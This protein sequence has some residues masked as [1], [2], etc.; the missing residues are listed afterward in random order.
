MAGCIRYCMVSSTGCT[1]LVV[2]LSNKDV[3]KPSL[4]ASMHTTVGGSWQWSPTRTADPLPL[5]C[6][7]G[8][9]FA[10]SVACAASSTITFANAMSESTGWSTL[11]HVQQTTSAFVKMCFSPSQ[12]L[13]CPEFIPIDLAFSTR[14]CF[15]KSSLV[16]SGRPT[17]TTF[18]PARAQPSTKLSTATLLSA[19]TNTGVRPSAVHNRTNSTAVWVLPVPGG[20]WINVIRRVA[21][22]LSASACDSLAKDHAGHNV[23]KLHRMPIVQRAASAPFAARSPSSSAARR[24]ALS[25]A[26]SLG[27][28]HIVRNASICRTKVTRLAA[29][30]TLHVPPAKLRTTSFDVPTSFTHRPFRAFP[31]PS[32]STSSPSKLATSKPECKKLRKSQ[33]PFCKGTCG[34][35]PR[36]LVSTMS[37]PPLPGNAVSKGI[38][39]PT[40]S[41]S[42]PGKAP[43]AAKVYWPSARNSRIAHFANRAK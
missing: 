33:S 11:L 14:L 27:T 37:R 22:A 40:R 19:E 42:P 26:S 13:V 21:A 38:L 5:R 8:I 34:R 30:S 25:H 24:V 1:P 3:L 39:S 10:N 6:K 2:S 29:L 17:R 35:R 7:R 18:S 28:S 41:E 9:K 20:P 43:I 36:W 23:G 32:K 31:M 15:S 16:T 12:C 4:L